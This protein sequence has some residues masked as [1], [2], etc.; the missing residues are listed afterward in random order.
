MNSLGLRVS[1]TVA[2]GVG[3]LVFIVLFLAFFAG[4]FDFWQ[5]LALFISSGAVALGIVAIVWIRWALK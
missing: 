1:V 2:A 5:K 4:N 3:W